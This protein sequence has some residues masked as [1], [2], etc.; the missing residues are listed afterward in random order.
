LGGQDRHATARFV[1]SAAGR[2]KRRWA[3]G[4]EAAI[5]VAENGREIATLVPRGTRRGPCDFR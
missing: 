5:K 4:P 1:V 2:T 3:D